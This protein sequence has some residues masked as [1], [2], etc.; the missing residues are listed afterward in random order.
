MF[1]LVCPK[2]EFE[3]SVMFVQQICVE[4]WICLLIRTV[5]AMSKRVTTL[6]TIAP[7]PSL[8]LQ[9]TNINIS[10]YI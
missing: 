6:P 7:P 2:I 1:G 3:P 10:N 4:T 8:L 9:S 5:L